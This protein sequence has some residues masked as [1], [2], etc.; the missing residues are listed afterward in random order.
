[1]ENCKENKTI[2]VV[3]LGYVGLPLATAFARH[4]NVVGFDLDSAK[5][6][7]IRRGTISSDLCPTGKLREALDSRQ[8]T[9]TDQLEAT[10]KAS[11]YIVAVPTPIDKELH[12]DPTL[13][14][15]A[16]RMVGKVLTP[17]DTVVFESTV[18]PGMTEDECVPLL[19]QASGLR[20]N[21][22]FTVGYSPERIN[23][24][25]SLHPVEK[26]TKIVAA[27]TPE[28]LDFVDALYSTFL[29]NGTYRAPSIRVAE[30][31][32]IMENCQRDVL[33]AFANEMYR[34]FGSMGIDVEEVIAAA[35]TKWNY[36]ETHPG[37]V[38]GHC[39]SVDPYYLI[40][41]AAAM[42]VATPLL[43]TART[44]NNRMAID[45]AR[46]IDSAAR[47]AKG[48]R[49]LLLGFAFKPDCDDIRNTRVADIVGELR[50][51]GYE[52]TVCDPLVDKAKARSVYGIDIVHQIPD[53]TEYAAIAVCT[54]HAVFHQP[55]F[56]SI[57]SKGE[58]IHLCPIGE[59][60]MRLQKK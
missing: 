35:R 60:V 57:S 55:P 39:I 33:I 15:N 22:G 51:R 8:L 19:E 2:C 13:L 17:G 30:G 34:V 23:P 29:E 27:S 53:N 32:K 11:V 1:M 43:S 44:I 26:I 20:L 59:T 50:L 12:A 31:A 10:R 9:V 48:N 3:G 54:E 14:L 4:F 40:D 42:G 49:V 18:S 6:D 47:L 45:Y 58:I 24:S 16:C 41:K 37:F 56:L 46:R 38:G 5:C 28:A 25:D 36:A 7:A 21:D 52:V